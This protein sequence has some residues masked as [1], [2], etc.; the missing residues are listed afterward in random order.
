M[1]YT[2]KQ[3]A[4]KFNLTEY[5]IR[6]YEKEGLLLD[7]QR[8]EHG[9]RLFSE[10]NIEWINLICCLRRTGMSIAKIKNF[11][12]LSTEGDNTLELRREIIL[13]QRAITEKKIEEMNNHLDMI[14]KKLNH[15]NGL[16]KDRNIRCCNSKCKASFVR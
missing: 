16:I 6:Y 15:Y 13:T 8:D 9:V 3:V 7:V 10:N 14:N 2:I 5:T 12:K 11:I 4:E 1:E